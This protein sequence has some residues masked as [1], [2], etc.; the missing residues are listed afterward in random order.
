MVVVLAGL[1]AGS[2]MLAA[3][4]TTAADPPNEPPGRVEHD[5]ATNVDR[6]VLTAAAATR[7][8]I[9]TQPVREAQIGGATR[10]VIPYAAV[11]YDANGETWTYTNPAPLVFV[12][13]RVTV[14]SIKGDQAVL[15]DGPATGTPVVTVGAPELYGTE[16]G[17]S[18]DE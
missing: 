15:T 8:A 18:G 10:R 6:V 5:S 3:R 12:R 16:F 9:T 17:V 1:I 4:G 14:E 11:L 2:A 7:L 13:Q